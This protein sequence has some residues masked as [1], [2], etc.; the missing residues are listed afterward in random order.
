[1]ATDVDPDG[2]HA[3]TSTTFSRSGK[4]EQ[5][6]YRTVSLHVLI[7]AVMGIVFLHP[8][9]KAVYWFEFRDSM[10]T[11]GDSLWLFLWHR[12]ETAFSFEMWP[13]SLAF[14]L[15]GGGI[16]LA[17]AYYHLRL[18]RQH[19]TILS[20]E[21]ELSEDLP[22]LIRSGE[23][24]RLEFKSSVRWDFHQERINKALV[25]VIAKSIAGFMNHQGGSLLVGVNDA[26]NIV[27]L[28]DDYKTFKHKNRDGFELF[29][30]DLVETRL[31]VA[32]CTLVH[33]SFHEVNGKDVCRVFV[34]P[35]SVPVYVQD[36][37]VARYYL[38]TGNGTRELDAREAH[39]HI[40]QN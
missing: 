6:K 36:G 30:N 27:G 8:L 1:M 26:G 17:F 40:V 35:S 14:A 16:G 5:V 3:K 31:G 33:C 2:E 34:E 15:I 12:Y 7:G 10:V 38:R 21:H 25:S 9:T 13:M 19:Q 24:E 28:L 11:D 23:S 39:A 32:M 4:A 29:I 20:L 37:K 22:S 18:L